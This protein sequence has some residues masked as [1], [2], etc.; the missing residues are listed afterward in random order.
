MAMSGERNR[1][2]TPVTAMLLVLQALA[3]GAVPLAHAAEP[4]TAP[5]SIEAHHDATCVVIHDAMRCALCLYFNSLTPPPP[6]P[7]V[8]VRVP[9]PARLAALAAVV[10]TGSA[11]Y[12][13]PQSRAPPIHLS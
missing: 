8:G 9:V 4:Q 2:T 5:G 1:S 11:P 13:A 7:P 3:G 10:G 12:L 6:A